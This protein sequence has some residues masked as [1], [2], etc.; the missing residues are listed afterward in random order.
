[1][2]DLRRLVPDARLLIVGDGPHRPE[3]ERLAAHLAPGTVTLAGAVPDQELPAYH[4]A[5]DVFAMPCR[6][7][8]GG[9]EVEGFG[10]VYLEAA[11]TARPAIAGHSGG[12]AEAVVDGDTGVLVEPREPKAVA[13]AIASLLDDPTRRARYGAAGRARVERAFTWAQRGARLG[14]ILAEAPR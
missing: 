4:A 13:L 6:S 5:A 12:A 14:Q 10:I 11:A 1:M 9:L 7:R 3:L 2:S 8:Y